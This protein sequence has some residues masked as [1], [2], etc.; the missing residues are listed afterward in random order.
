[1]PQLDV[2]YINDIDAM[3]YYFDR[4]LNIFS[5]ATMHE[6]CKKLLLARSIYR[7]TMLWQR[8]SYMIFRDTM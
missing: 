6:T 4:S 1:M 7:K 8:T 5:A 3:R 2:K